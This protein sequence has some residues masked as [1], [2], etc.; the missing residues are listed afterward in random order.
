MIMQPGFM[1]NIFVALLV[2]SILVRFGFE[3][4]VAHLTSY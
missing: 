1:K 3:Y 2:L 4:H